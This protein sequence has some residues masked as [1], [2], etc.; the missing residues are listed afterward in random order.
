ME[1]PASSIVQPACPITIEIMPIPLMM[2]M[3]GSLIFSVVFIVSFC[4]SN[5]NQNLYL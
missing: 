3:Y 4:L 5:K 1:Q 2:S